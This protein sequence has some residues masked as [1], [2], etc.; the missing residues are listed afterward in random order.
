MWYRGTG[1]LG[2]D[3]ITLNDR[4]LVFPDSNVSSF[5][6]DDTEADVPS[7]AEDISNAGENNPGR[8]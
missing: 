4:Q 2:N 3:E 6:E 1:I 7:L 8:W 5:A